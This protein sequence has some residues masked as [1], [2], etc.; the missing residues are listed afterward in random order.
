MKIGFIGLGAMG[1]AI[2][3]NLLKAGHEAAVWNRSADKA[4]PL[5]ALGAVRV[6]TPAEAADGEVVFTMLAN[7]EALER[8]VFAE[9]GLLNGG[10][11]IHVSMSTI[12]VALAERLTQAHATAGAIFV[13]APV[14][15]RPAA[16]E[17]ARL[18]VVAAGPKE[19]LDFCEPLFAAVGQRTFRVGEA[20]KMA[21]VIKLAGNFMIMS[22]IESLAEALTFGANNGVDKA[23]LLDVLT[24]TLFDAPVFRT[25]GDILVGEKFEPAGFAA[26]LGL[27]DM[28]L[29]DAAALAAK[30]PMPFLGVLRGQLLTA[31]ARH[32]ADVDWSCIARVVEEN[33]GPKAR[34]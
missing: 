29:V 24:N 7:D 4:K 23:A 5:E 15:G 19:A 2:A 16:A 14:F 34:A 30:V 12:G 17:A 20:P 13:S 22:A 26:P 10:R 8:V 3:A 25:Y 6:E 32:G 9:D 28:N 27:K 21:N 1:G 31:I 18:S 33:S 11:P